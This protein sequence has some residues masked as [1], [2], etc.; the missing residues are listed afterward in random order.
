M[1]IRGGKKG[2]KCEKWF[3]FYSLDFSVKAEKHHSKF[4]TA[5]TFRRYKLGIL[6][7][8][9]GTQFEEF[10]FFNAL[11][12]CKICKCKYLISN[13]KSA[14]EMMKKNSKVVTV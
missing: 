13:W 11:V 10:F 5:S 14:K 7:D 8:Q 2:E 4:S 12:T 3:C 6:Q 9:G 1:K